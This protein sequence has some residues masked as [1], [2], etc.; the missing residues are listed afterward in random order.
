MKPH[1]FWGAAMSC[2]L[3]LAAGCL[4]L[5]PEPLQLDTVRAQWQGRPLDIEPIAAYAAALGGDDPEMLGPFDPSDGLSLHEAQAVALWYNAELRIKRLEALRAGAATARAALWPDPELSVTGGEQEVAGS[6]LVPFRQPDGTTSLREV[7]VIERAWLSVISLDL[8]IPLSGAPKARQR[9]HR[10]EH[11]V[12]EWRAVEAEWDVLHE[13]KRLWIDWS[14]S[15]EHARLL[16]AHVDL[17]GRITPT[18]TG[19]AEA[20]E[21]FPAYARMLSIEQ[22]R[23]ETE[24]QRVHSEAQAQRAAILQALGLAPG[25][26]VDLVPAIP[27]GDAAANRILEVGNHPRVERLRAAYQ[28]AE[29]RLR[30]ELREQF[31]DLT[32]SPSYTDQLDEEILSVGLGFPVPAWHRNR[33]AIADAAGA[34]DVARAE[35]EAGYLGLV[36]EAHQAQMAAAAAR[37][38]QEQLIEAIAP[39]LDAQVQ[40]VFALLEVGEI[41]LLLVYEALAQT[42]DVKQQIL[43][44]SVDLARNTARLEAATA[45]GVAPL[46]YEEEQRQ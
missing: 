43:E 40:E 3:P 46:V 19:L 20:G 22:K 7:P 2:A 10:T 21:L 30:L 4:H 8:T 38:R 26:A 17:M 9:L 18:A 37:A 42:L 16:E 39:Q 11:A 15:L 36:A 44:T 13:V 35:A 14:A 33:P 29:D 45:L 27:H 1:I 31:P 6:R 24:V 12:A 34:R 28:A 41:D 23:V 25:A 5:P 32:L